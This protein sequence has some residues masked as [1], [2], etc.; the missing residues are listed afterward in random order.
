MSPPPMNGGMRSSSSRRAHS[1]PMPG[2]AVQLVAGEDVEIGA[3]RLHVDRRGARPPGCRRTAPCAPCCMRERRDPRRRRHRAEHVAHMGDRDQARPGRPAAGAPARPDR[4]RRA[5]VIGAIRSSIPVRVA[6]HLPRHQVGV[7]LH[8]GDHHRLVRP[9]HAAAIAVRHEVDRLGGVL[10]E[11]DL[12][13]DP[14]HS[15]AGRPCRARPHRPPR[16]ARSS[17]AGR[18][19]RWRIASPS[20]APWR[21]S[22]GAA[23]ARRRRCRGRRAAC[24]ARVCAQDGEVGADALDVE[25]RPG[26]D[27]HAGCLSHQASIACSSRA[28]APSCATGRIASA[29]K[30]RTRIARAASSGMPRLR[31]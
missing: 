22:P 8:L 24:R 25:G 27:V 30:A 3:D 7:V 6:Q 28:R 14:A 29:R 4:A 17:N 1:T 26:Q 20:P 23:S 9:H 11:H 19:A 16:S 10:G 31:R 15:A 2:R 18:D 5:S 12:A 13:R 21:R